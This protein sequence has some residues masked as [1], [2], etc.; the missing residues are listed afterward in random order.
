MQKFYDYLKSYGGGIL[1]GLFIQL[2]ITSLSSA[3]ADTRQP[4]EHES[5]DM[6]VRVNRSPGI[7]EEPSEV[8]TGDQAH[9][10]SDLGQN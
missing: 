6:L 3:D 5:P 4:D 8:P 9:L 10:Y 2:L 7:L 1:F